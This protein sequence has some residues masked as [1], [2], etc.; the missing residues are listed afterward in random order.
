MTPMAAI[1]LIGFSVVTLL[2]LMGAIVGSMWTARGVDGLGVACMTAGSLFWLG[3]V[4]YYG[5][6]EWW[7]S[8]Y[9]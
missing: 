1:A 4:V 9:R 2:A 5:G 3:L 6:K 8:N 7:E